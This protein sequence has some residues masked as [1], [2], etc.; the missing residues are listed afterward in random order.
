MHFFLCSGLSWPKNPAL[1]FWKMLASVFL[2]AILGTSHCLMFVPLINI[3]LLLG[4]P[5]LPTRWVKLSTHL[6]SGP[7]LS[8]TFILINLKLLIIFVHTPNVLCYVFLSYH[9]L[10]TSLH[11]CLFVYFSRIIVFLFS[12]VFD[13]MLCL[14]IMQLPVSTL[15]CVCN[16]PCGCWLGM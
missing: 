4:A 12:P 1:P 8:I 9:V 16:W 13:L 7:F 5:M 6:Q 14:S 3:V 15:C 10:V 11:I 2:P